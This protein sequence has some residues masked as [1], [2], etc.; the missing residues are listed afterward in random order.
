MHA[1]YLNVLGLVCIMFINVQCLLFQS[2]VLHY[3]LINAF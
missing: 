1:N 3:Y 2:P